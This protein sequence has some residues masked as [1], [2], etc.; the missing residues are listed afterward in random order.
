MTSGW[1]LWLNQAA[2]ALTDGKLIA[3]SRPYGGNLVLNY[4]IT[5]G[6][7]RGVALPTIGDK[8][9]VDRYTFE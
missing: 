6:R 4:R 9:G 2:L 3:R 8:I 7:L 5:K 1:E